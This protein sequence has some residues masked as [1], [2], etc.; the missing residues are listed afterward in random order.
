MG[1]TVPSHNGSVIVLD[2]LE[3]G[4]LL[5]AA[6]IQSPSRQELV[7]IIVCY[8]SCENATDCFPFVPRGRN[9]GGW[10]FGWMRRGV[11]GD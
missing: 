8:L 4:S 11:D 2:T 9:D 3:Y 10:V 7:A 6:F 1:Q 5:T